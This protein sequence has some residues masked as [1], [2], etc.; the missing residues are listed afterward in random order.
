MSESI[1]VPMSEP[2]TPEARQ[3]A[4]F[5]HLGGFAGLTGI[6]GAGL[7]V[8]FILWQMKKEQHPF[9]DDQGKEA[10]NF[11]ICMLIVIVVT[12]ALMCVGIGVFIFPIVALVGIVMPILAALKANEGVVY[13][14]PYIFR[15]IK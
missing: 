2:P 13:R 9:I 1:D 3:W 7:L 11:Q 5:C 4:M 10:M 12:F 15:L 8:P 14:Y 6:P